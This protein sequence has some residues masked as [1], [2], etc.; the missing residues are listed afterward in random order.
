[1]EAITYIED[2]YVFIPFPKICALVFGATVNAYL[3]LTGY[4]H[5]HTDNL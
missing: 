2:I 5:G 3:T 1:M 4:L